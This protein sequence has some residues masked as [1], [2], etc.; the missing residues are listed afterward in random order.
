MGGNQIDE[1]SLDLGYKLTEVGSVILV[2]LKA[3][4]VATT[5]SWKQQ[6]D[7]FTS[8]HWK[9]VQTHHSAPSKQQI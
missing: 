6:T 8:N 3:I 7:H 1:I 2:N 9:T 4:I 5:S